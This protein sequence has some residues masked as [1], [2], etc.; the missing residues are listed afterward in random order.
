MLMVQQHACQYSVCVPSGWTTRALADLSQLEHSTK[1]RSQE[2]TM[3]K[4]SSTMSFDV[5]E[6]EQQC[7]SLKL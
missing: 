4:I 5:C 2:Q 3:I 6:D 1:S 7:C